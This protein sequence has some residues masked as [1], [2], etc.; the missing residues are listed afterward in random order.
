MISLIS[1]CLASLR[2]DSPR[3]SLKVKCCFL[4]VEEDLVVQDQLVSSWSNF[5]KLGDPTPPGSNYSWSA[6][7]GRIEDGSNQWYF[8]ISGSQSAMDSSEEIFNRFKIWD[9]VLAQDLD[10]F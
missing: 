9:Q 2:L 8:N 1:L 10:I 5:V 4:T 3:L 6:V 7:D